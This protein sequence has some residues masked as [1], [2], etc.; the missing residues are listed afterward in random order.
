MKTRLAFSPQHKKLAILL[1][2]AGILCFI[3]YW[4]ATHS[5]VSITV[6]NGGAGEL[7]YEL[8][9]QRSGTT[10]SIKG[11]AKGL[12]VLVR[13]GNYEVTVQSS[14]SSSY[15]TVHATKNFMQKSNITATLVEED[16]REFVGN[17]PYPCIVRSGAVIASYPCSGDFGSLK[18]H[19]P[20]TEKI[21]SY[22][23]SGKRLSSESIE[24]II[25]T[26]DGVVMLVKMPPTPRTFGYHALYKLEERGRQPV[27]PTQLRQL[28]EL[29]GNASFAILPY[30]DGFITYNIE[31][32]SI[33]YYPSVST[34]DGQRIDIY[35]KKTNNTSLVG[36]N[37]DGTNISAIYSSGQ[38]NPD[39]YSEVL[40]GDL[41]TTSYLRVDFLV[42]AAQRCGS[43][44][45]CLLGGKGEFSVYTRSSDTY[46]RSVVIKDARSLRVV[47]GVPLIVNNGGVVRFD[48]ETGVGH[49]SFR[50]SD[51]RFVSSS[52][53]REG[54]YL[55]LTDYKNNTVVLAFNSSAL[56][57]D[58]IDKQVLALQ[59]EPLVK[60]V[61]AYEK[62]IFI[63]PDLGEAQYDSSLDAFTY[64]SEDVNRND[65][66]IKQLLQDIGIDTTLYTVINTSL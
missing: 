49:F 9:D 52:L 25:E 54:Y 43:D 26:E 57:G 46:H 29:D 23:V 47:G 40:V 22:P 42:S 44:K 32:G 60:N 51:Y 17:N 31:D 11:D 2:L 55:N 33:F 59:H 14:A 39:T 36:I 28:S 18:T 30:E 15:Y 27:E 63:T 4:L 35:K 48:T 21:P 66:R 6:T 37:A 10:R 62:Y 61:T 1:V 64:S 53:G 7:T 5:F 16:V 13:T 65:K 20:A 41:K 8:F 24:G 3:V 34:G 56:S 12:T 45:V 58:A 38:E 19:L 50:F